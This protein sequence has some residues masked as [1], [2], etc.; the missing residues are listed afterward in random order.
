MANARKVIADSVATKVTLERYTSV[1]PDRIAVVPL[2]VG[3]A[4]R[5][6]PDDGLNLRASI[7]V[8]GRPAVLLHVATKYGYKNT[9]GLLHALAELR[10]RLE[11]D[12]ILVR[13]GAPLSPDE[14]Q[15]A[16][17]LGVAGAIRYVGVVDDE[18]LIQWYNAADLFVFP[19]LWEGFGWPPLEA[20]A[21]GTPVVASDVPAIAEVVG[22]AGILVP[23]HDPAAFARAAERVLMDP[24]LAA[25]LRQRGIARASH[26][27]WARSA[28]ATVAV[29]DEVLQ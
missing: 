20:M 23:L 10:S 16:A 9:E 21:C 18:T 5:R 25:T 22:D 17:R 1:P 8:S 4:F 12:A 6:L 29:Y 13:V 28:A 24:A 7:D 14:M 2:G 15:L 19:S 11:R 26:F 27:T 3:G